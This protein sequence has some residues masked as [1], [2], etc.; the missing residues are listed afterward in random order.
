[1]PLPCLQSLPAPQFPVTQLG[2]AHVLFLQRNCRGHQCT[3]GAFRQSF[4]HGLAACWGR[5]TITAPRQL[6]YATAGTAPR[7]KGR[8]EEGSE[9]EQRGFGFVFC[10]LTDTQTGKL[11]KKGTLK[12]QQLLFKGILHASTVADYNSCLSLYT[13]KKFT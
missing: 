5:C 10:M 9:A 4:S 1:M 12:T 8:V 6:S 3:E 7:E 11:N 2:E 13:G